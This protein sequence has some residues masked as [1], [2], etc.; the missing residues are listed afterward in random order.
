[1][2]LA[3]YVVVLLPL[4]PLWGG[5]PV[6]ETPVWNLLLL[7]FGAPVALAWLVGRLHEPATAAIAGKVA[8]LALFVFVSLEIRHLWQGRLDVAIPTGDGEM[9]TYSVVWLCMAV[10][11]VLAGEMRG[12]R[13]VYRAGMALLVLTACKVFLVDMAGLTGL[14]RAGSFLGLGLSLLGLAYLH[15]RLGRSN[16]PPDARL[17]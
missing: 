17:P 9:A 7:A 6:G 2:A 4:N 14:L 11:A 5:D 8:P 12:R 13:G 10:P 16:S 15:Q 3:N 1:M